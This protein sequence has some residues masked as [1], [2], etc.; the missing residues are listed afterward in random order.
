MRLSQT[1]RAVLSLRQLLLSGEFAPGTRMSEIP[2]VERLG[3]SRTPLRLALARL[4]HEGL[5]ETLAGGGYVV[6]Q[7]T[8]ADINDAI[9]LR[10]VLE[11][12][13]ARLAAERGVDRSHLAAMR[14]CCDR[15]DVVV[16][17]S[18][19]DSFVRYMDLNQKFHALLLEA[20]RSPVLARAVE[21]VVA[22]PF[23]SPSAFVLAQA[24]IPE[25]REILVVAQNHHRGIVEAITNREGARAEGIAREHARVSLR[26]LEI[27]LRNSEALERVPGGSLIKLP[28][29]MNPQQS[30]ESHAV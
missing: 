7:F 16:H 22:L 24:E 23:A 2:L 10:G 30:G 12:T 15:M 8:Q 11:G 9:E 17:E 20:A 6:K 13:A 27:V 14:V 29:K 5:L 3:V 21:G 19:E 1:M 4:E 28:D 18:D 26:N 25:S